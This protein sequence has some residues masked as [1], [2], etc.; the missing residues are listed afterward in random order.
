[1]KLEK[2]VKGILIPIGGSEDKGEKSNTRIS[3][4]EKG[5][6]RHVLNEAKGVESKVVVIPTASRIPDE[7]G[8]NYISAFKKLG[9]ENVIVLPISRKN[10]SENQDFI[11]HVRDADCILF[12]GGNQSRIET[13]IRNSSLH[14]IVMDRFENEPLVVAGTSAGAMAMASEMIAGGTSSGALLKGAVKMR[15]GLG[16]FPDVIIDTHFIKRGRFGRL[17]EALARFPDKVGIGLADDT[18][19]IIK[20]LNEGQVIG[21]G[22]VLLMDPSGLTHNS[23]DLLKTN[24]P[25]SVAGMK[26]HILANGD[27]IKLDTREIAVL[28]M[29]ESFV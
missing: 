4:R 11:R 1:M 24:M 2:N 19:L 9:C 12:T 23:Y 5:V 15:S 26:V 28:P 27:R 8:Q 14:R 20:N 13:K 7:V 6:L 22:M 25:V 3:F 10:H 29:T 21:S 17:F 16:L 18:G